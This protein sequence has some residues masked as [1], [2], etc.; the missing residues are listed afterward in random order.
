MPARLTV[1]PRVSATLT[2]TPRVS[3]TL[4]VTAGLETS[5]PVLVSAAIAANGTTLTLVFDQRLTA[6]D[7]SGFGL[8]AFTSEEVTYV[9]GDL[10]DTLVFTIAR[11]ISSS[12]TVTVAYTPGV[13]ENLTDDA[14]A[15]FSGFAVANNS[16][17][18]ATNAVPSFTAGNVFG[19]LVGHVVTFNV[20]TL[21]DQLTLPGW[22]VQGRTVIDLVPIDPQTYE[23]TWSGNVTN[24][25]TVIV[26]ASDPAIRTQN[27]GFVAAGA[28]PITLV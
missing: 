17:Q 1:T 8:V 28:Y 16:A 5:A 18:P 13:V 24:P 3:A 11:A 27:A 10:S 6:A 26:G 7:W 15:A 22:T 25:A 2:V 14:L 19:N 21:W 4:T 20:S 12:E 23:I 9:S